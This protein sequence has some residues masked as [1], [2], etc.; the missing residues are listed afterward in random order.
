MPATPESRIDKVF[1]RLEAAAWVKQLT[2]SQLGFLT[3]V[4]NVSITKH[5]LLPKSS[6]K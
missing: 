2:M 3:E 1:T 6:K 5:L 4:M